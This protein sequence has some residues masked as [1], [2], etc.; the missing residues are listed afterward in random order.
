L[1][2]VEIVIATPGRLID[3]LEA[4]HTNLQRV[5]YLVLDEADR[6]LDMGFEPQIRKIVNQVG[7]VCDQYVIS[8][9]LKKNLK[10][11]SLVM[12]DHVSS[13]L[14]FVVTRS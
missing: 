6:M 4:Q 11:D 7:T 10:S 14:W 12:M 5:T 1:A 8:K 2:G 3:M 13:A 9:Q